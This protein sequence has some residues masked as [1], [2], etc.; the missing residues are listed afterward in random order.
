MAECG[1]QPPGGGSGAAGA[2]SRHEKS[3]G[4]LTTKFVSLLQEA[5][6]GV[7]DL[8]LAADTLAVRQKRRIYDITNVLEGIGLIEKKSK[9]S[10]QWNGAVIL[11]QTKYLQHLGLEKMPVMARE[12]GESPAS[13]WDVGRCTQRCCAGRGV[14]PGCNTREIAHKLIELKADI[15]DLEQREQELEQQKMWVQQSIKNVTEDVQN[16]RLAYVTHEDICKCFTGDTLL[17]IRAPSGTRLEVPIPEGLNGQKK[18][19]IH[20]KST[21]GPIDVLL[22][23]KDAWSS[24]PVVLPVP[25]PEDL[26]QCQAVA[27]S[28]PQIPPLA[29]FQEAS[30]PSSTQPSTPTPTSTQDHSPPTQK[31]AGTECGVSAA[32]SKSSGDFEPLG[33]AGL[34]TQ[35]LQ[36]SASLDSGS[37]LPSP[38]TSFEPIKPDPTGK[39]MNSELLEELMSSE[40]FAPL[41]R[42]SPPPGDHDYIYNLD[43]SEGVCDLFDV[44][45]LNL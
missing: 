20:L 12:M 25:P 22:V 28:K 10:I 40:V 36:S 31:A 42:L 8:K 23:N 14:G 41:L 34:D 38:S 3:L 18:Y 32:E 24:P 19:Q 35:P 1:P 21:S 6:D 16:S 29:H 45:V 43:E 15:E 7:L 11:V 5:K 17:A 44:P 26:I 33:S 4:L 37:I 27:P 9:N 13:L 30:V 2:P 39:C